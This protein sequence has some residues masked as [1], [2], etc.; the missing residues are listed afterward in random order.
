MIGCKLQPLWNLDNFVM[1]LLPLSHNAFS[2]DG[3]LSHTIHPV[4]C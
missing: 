4:V 3:A 1:V 2:M